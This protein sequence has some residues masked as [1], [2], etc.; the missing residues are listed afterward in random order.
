LRKSQKVD[1]SIDRSTVYRAL[2]LLKRQGLIDE[3]DLM[4]LNGE[5]RYY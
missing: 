3:L 4:H 1:A 2:G 5:G